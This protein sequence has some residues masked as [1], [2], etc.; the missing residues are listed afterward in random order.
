MALTDIVSNTGTDLMDRGDIGTLEDVDA[1]DF[2]DNLFIDVPLVG[3]VQSGVQYGQQ[4][5]EL[6]GTFVGGGGGTA[7]PPVVM[8]G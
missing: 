4:G 5:D 7:F 8:G 1:P 6:T 3:E 2:V